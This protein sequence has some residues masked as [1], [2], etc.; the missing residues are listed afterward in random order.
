M[1]LV[2]FYIESCVQNL[3]GTV[4][5][6]H[7]FIIISNQIVSLFPV[8]IKFDT[9]PALIDSFLIMP[10]FGVAYAFVGEELWQRLL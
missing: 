4:Q 10:E 6:S 1:C 7:F 5:L 3:Q 8:F 9:L 2:V